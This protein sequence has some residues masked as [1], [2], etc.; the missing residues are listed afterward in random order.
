MAGLA[1]AL[2]LAVVRIGVAIEAAGELYTSPPRSGVRTGRVAFLAG[3]VKVRAL[4]WIARP[5]VI[6]LDDLPI[7]R[8]VALLAL[9]AQS[10]AVRVLVTRDAGGWEPQEGAVEVLHADAGPLAGK[11]AIRRVALK[12][13]RTS[14]FAF[15]EPSGF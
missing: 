7:L 11:N 1:G 12:A 13:A 14:V 3:D 9:L 4:E 15:Q 5:G 2:E 10:A 6:K 8:V